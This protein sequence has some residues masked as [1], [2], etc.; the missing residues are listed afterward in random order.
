MNLLQHHESPR[1]WAEN[2]FSGAEM[3]DIRRIDRVVTI[4][5]AMAASPGKS[6]PDMFA[7]TYDVKATYGLF[8]HQEATPDNLQAGH[9]DLVK[10]QIQD[11]GVYLLIEDT[12]DMSW[13]DNKPIPGLALHKKSILMLDVVVF[14]CW[15]PA[16]RIFDG[17]FVQSPLDW[18]CTKSP[19]CTKSGR[20][21]QKVLQKILS[22]K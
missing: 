4:A 7:S 10:Q 22:T 14:R 8:K 9:R 16:S 20:S 11:Q 21:A 3:S 2:N 6:I 15:T 18:L 5:E 17:L 19:T 13:S 1:I 12:T